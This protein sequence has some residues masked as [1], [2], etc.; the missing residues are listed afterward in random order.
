M[1]LSRDLYSNKLKISIEYDGIWHFENINGQ[2]LNKQK[3]DMALE[4]WTILNGWRLIRIKEDLYKIDKKLW[5]DRLIESVYNSSE[6][7]I[8]IY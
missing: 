7:I 4:D 3:K 5:L 6:Q 1:I 8:K 2:L